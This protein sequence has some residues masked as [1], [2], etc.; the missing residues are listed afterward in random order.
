MFQCHPKANLTR[1][2]MPNVYFCWH[3]SAW[4]PLT[5]VFFVCNFLSIKVKPEEKDT[6]GQ[7]NPPSKYCKQHHRL[8][9]YTHLI[10][11]YLK[12]SS[13]ACQ[14]K[15]IKCL[16]DASNQ[17]FSF[18]E[19]HFFFF[20]LLSCLCISFFFGKIFYV[21]NH[22]LILWP[23]LINI[24]IITDFKW[25]HS[26]PEAKA[27]LLLSVCLSVCTKTH[28]TC[29]EWVKEVFIQFWYG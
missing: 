19:K 11:K 29:E 16:I 4:L 25:K 20:F 27:D 10:P 21:M 26:L 22:H 9:W 8:E 6:E 18:I 12:S 1:R 28:Q 7:K 3:K 24:S 13:Q 23:I 15:E 2:H 5:Y 17:N 14:R